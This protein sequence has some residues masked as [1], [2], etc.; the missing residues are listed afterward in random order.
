MADSIQKFEAE[1]GSFRTR[2]LDESV[3]FGENSILTLT[4][5]QRSSV[6]DLA[7]GVLRRTFTLREFARL[8]Q[9][10]DGGPDSS[11]PGRWRAVLPQVLRSRS[12]HPLDPSFDDVIDHYR[13]PPDIGRWCTNW[14]L[15]YKL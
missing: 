9:G 8:F 11:G 6:I 3:L 1:S 15:L 4:R 12:A 5:E 13:R 7:P 2:Q 14:F 10:L